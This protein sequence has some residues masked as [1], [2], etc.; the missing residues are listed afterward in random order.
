MYNIPILFIIFNRFDTT[1]QVFEQIRKQKP[2][3]LYIAADGPRKNREDDIENCKKTREIVNKIDWDCELKTL[4][5]DENLGCGIAPSN[6]IKW[7]FDNE[8]MGIILEDD[9]LPHP[10]FFPYCE[11]LLNKYKDDSQVKIVSGD[12]FQNGITRGNASYYFSAYTHIW[13]WAT[14]RRTWDEYSF[15]LDNISKKEFKNI[16][17]QYSFSWNERQV[18]LDKFLL[19][20]KKTY[21][22]WDYQFNFC[23]WKNGGL[24]ILP[25]VNLVSNIGFGGNSTHAFNAH[26]KLDSLQTQQICPINHPNKI[27]R[28]IKGD[29]YFYNYYWKKSFLKILYRTLCRKLK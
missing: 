10:D 27:E 9:C 7:L 23:V 6:A 1:E 21:D 4:F 2:K 12:N 17:K 11:E 26:N 24:S 19:L 18:W 3:Y 8:E 20:K 16:L 29:E 13:G 5:R 25:N 22:I 28:D 14:W 15:S